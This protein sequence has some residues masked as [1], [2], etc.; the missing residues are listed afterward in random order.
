MD[1]LLLL[2]RQAQEHS[3]FLPNKSDIFRF[4]LLIYL[5][6]HDP[7]PYMSLSFIST[8]HQKLKRTLLILVCDIML[9]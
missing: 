2:L 7:G 6:V 1:W 4:A 9:Y 5:E 8:I 3:T